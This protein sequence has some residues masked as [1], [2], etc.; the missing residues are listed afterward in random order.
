MP[1]VHIYKWSSTSSPCLLGILL[2]LYIMT[3]G[4]PSTHENRPATTA[5]SPP[6]SLILIRHQPVDSPGFG[7]T[8]SYMCWLTTTALGS[9]Y[10]KAL[11]PLVWFHRLVTPVSTS[12][13]SI[14]FMKHQSVDRLD[15]LFLL[16]TCADLRQ[17]LL[18]LHMSWPSVYWFIYTGL[19]NLSVHL[20]PPQPS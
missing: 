2:L 19:Q 11:V 6:C 13:I 5:S 20:P 16:L 4:G 12:P 9:I 7:T 15:M 18:L 10:I 14:V 8:S 17:L 3:V 1:A